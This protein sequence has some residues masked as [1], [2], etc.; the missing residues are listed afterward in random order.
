M[1]DLKPCGTLAA[2]RRHRRLREDV[3]QACREAQSAYMRQYPRKRGRTGNPR[4]RRPDERNYVLAEWVSL[5]GPHGGV[6]FRE[7]AARVG[8]R[9]KAWERLFYRAREAGDPRAVRPL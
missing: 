2:C 4:G 3:D 8:K 7:F 6:D 5:G 9:Y 1:R